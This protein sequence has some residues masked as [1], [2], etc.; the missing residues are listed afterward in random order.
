MS[1]QLT[2]KMTNK[3]LKQWLDFISTTHSSEIEMGLERVKSVFASMSY[4]QNPPIIVM[5][6]GTN[7]KGSTVAMIEQGLLALD[8]KVGSYTSPH[9]L[10]YNER[11]Q[12]NA[13]QVSDDTL[14][15][16]FETVDQRR[17]DIPLTYFEFGT[18][19]ALDILL[20]ASLDVIVLE[21]GLGGRLDAVNIVEPDISIITSIGIDHADWLGDTVEKIG[22]EKAGILRSN[23]L[24]IGGEDL[25]QSVHTIAKQLA[26]QTLL[27]R[28]DFN[29]NS[30]QD[31]LPAQFNSKLLNK[32]YLGFPTLLLPENN[33][34]IALQA[35]AALATREAKL[36]LS[37]DQQTYDRVVESINALNLPGRLERIAY[38]DIDN[39]YLDVG[40]NPHAALYLNTFLMQHAASGKKIQ[41]VY[42]ALLD[43]DVLGV[44]GALSPQV[45]RCLL[46]PLDV[47]RAMP[48]EDI[49]RYAEKSGL[50]DIIST[51]SLAE[52]FNEAIDYVLRMKQQ[53]QTV[54]TLIF[55]SF[56][57]VEAA[58]RF[59][60][61]YD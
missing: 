40:H 4:P 53:G 27:C 37:F 41:I 58:K 39:L 23:A 59:F 52:G 45:D 24:F 22:I 18:L 28:E 30:A 16:A 35:I 43:K 60:G 36:N 42:S 46:V 38:Q 31:Q 26:C 15:S 13:Q 34:L 21:V 33:I 32:A 20:N 44:L 6:A 10:K 8:L 29:N 12:I 11:V 25:P 5:V 9:I 19:A 3:S 17:S 56:F 61:N 7:G 55:G 14:V 51:D 47:E 54:L 1:C 49:R 50:N 2:P 48:L 57:M